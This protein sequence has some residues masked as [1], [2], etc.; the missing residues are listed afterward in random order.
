MVTFESSMGLSPQRL[1]VY[2][3]EKNGDTVV[4]SWTH[5]EIDPAVWTDGNLLAPVWGQPQ[6]VK[7]LCEEKEAAYRISDG[8]R[9][10][11]AETPIPKEHAGASVWNTTTH[12]V[13]PAEGDMTLEEAKTIAQTALMDE[14]GLTAEEA[15]VPFSVEDYAYHAGQLVVDGDGTRMWELAFNMMLNGTEYNGAVFINSQTGAVEA[16]EYTTLGNG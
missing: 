14:F 11:P 1:G 12:E 6:L 10:S 7:A 8:E 3:V 2:M 9:E 16:V 4:A 5:D 15:A 13:E